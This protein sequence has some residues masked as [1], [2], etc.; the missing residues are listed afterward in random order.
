MV[1]AGAAALGFAAF[2]VT[3][4]APDRASSPGAEHA[5]A[6]GQAYVKPCDVNQVRGV[7]DLYRSFRR[8]RYADP[9]VRSKFARQFDASRQPVTKYSSIEG[10]SF[11]EAEP[12]IRIESYD[13]PTLRTLHNTLSNGP[14]K[15]GHA[16]YANWDIKYDWPPGSMV[17]ANGGSQYRLDM[18]KF[19]LYLTFEVTLP[20]WSARSAQSRRDQSI[21]NRFKCDL[22]THEIRHV[23]ISRTVALEALRETA[24]MRANTY[25]GLKQKIEAHWTETFAELQRR[26]TAFDAADKI[27]FVG[28]F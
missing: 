15:Y 25:Q 24:E 14:G 19:K 1:F 27:D 20:A 6:A 11:F 21:W 18:S 28:R 5:A 22:I 12:I 10:L 16:G 26:Q 2:S 13:D 17:P 9:G 4:G 7:P 3:R 23:D 8:T